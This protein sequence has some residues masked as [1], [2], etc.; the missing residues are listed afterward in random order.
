[1]A[2]KQ[3]AP[4]L[5]CLTCVGYGRR[6]PI[7][8]L[9]NLNGSSAL[10]ALPGSQSLVQVDQLNGRE[11]GKNIFY[12]FKLLGK[13]LL[14]IWNLIWHKSL[15]HRQVLDKLNQVP[16]FSIVEAKGKVVPIADADGNQRI[17]WFTNASAAHAMLEEIVKENRDFEGLHLRAF[18]LGNVLEQ[19]NSFPGKKHR[20]SRVGKLLKSCDPTELPES[21]ES[22]LREKVATK[23]IEPGNWV[24]PV[25]FSYAFW[26]K[27]TVPFFFDALEL[28]E[29]LIYL[30]LRG[31]ELQQSTVVM[32]LRDL[33][34]EMRSTN[35]FRW[36]TVEF[37]SSREAHKLA[38][39]VG[40]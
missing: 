9:E 17:C 10:S 27:K 38:S 1:M 26:N 14:F 24:L 36:K 25:F 13:L 35:T 21:V 23:G 19:S 3:F 2:V 4:L 5:V 22:T 11:T 18:P 29:E 40:W 7:Q 6:V 33:V 34:H 16:A 32:D 20:A 28:K 15:T 39:T 30:G 12:P 8:N 31:K 37:V